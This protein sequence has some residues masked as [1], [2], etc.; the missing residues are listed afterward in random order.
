MT[1]KPAGLPK[2]HQLRTRA[3]DIGGCTAGLLR[4]ATPHEADALL[5]QIPSVRARQSLNS[6]G[7]PNRVVAEAMLRR[8]DKEHLGWLVVQALRPGS[9]PVLLGR[10]LDLDDPVVNER[11]MAAP[12][13]T[14]VPRNLR[15]QLAHQTSRRDGVTPVP[16]PEGLR[17][18]PG[19]GDRAS[20]GPDHALL[21]AA[22]AGLAARALRF[23]GAGADP[24]GAARACRTMLDAGLRDELRA[25]VDEG[26]LP[27]YRWGPHER[28]P[29]VLDYARDALAGTEGERRLRELSE[30]V[31]KPEMLR[32]IGEMSDSD[33]RSTRWEDTRLV[34]TR[35]DRRNPA[36]PRV[37]WAAVLA[38]EPR[39][40]AADGALPRFAAKIMAQRADVPLELVRAVVADHPELAVFL[41]DPVPR[42]LADL[43]GQSPRPGT[44]V[45][46]KVV[47]NGLAAGTLTPQDVVEIVPEELL[48]SVTGALWLPGLRGLAAVRTLVGLAGDVEL[49]PFFV[50]ETGA[51]TRR[52]LR[53][54]RR[55]AHWH[56]GAVYGPRLAAVLRARGD[57][58]MT[59]D[60]VLAEADTDAILAAS[61][62]APPDPRVLR[63]LAEH[64]HANLSGRPEAW[65][66]AL[67]LLEDGFAGSLP[68]LLG[69]AAEATP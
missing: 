10:L 14:D 39:R 29:S 36:V 32:S 43:C 60:E 30:R 25:L 53:D 68:E 51:G 49:D 17:E 7:M 21:H 22:D 47:G 50:D 23:L 3:A 33:A 5:G 11:L 13:R 40:R 16:L 6:Y 41:S 12:G 35:V 37:D 27:A 65:M 8:G 9:W 28:E 34:R 38:D 19:P 64:V 66:A 57:R 69:A 44:P 55:P 2:A 18:V 52:R 48:E 63:R 15:R 45:V 24:H 58:G 59:A 67:K 46:T 31:R 1:P 26:R 56:P 62:A 54:P 20:L 61:G 4:F 42:V